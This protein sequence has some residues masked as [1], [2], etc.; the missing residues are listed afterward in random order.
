MG[1][2]P[3]RPITV[4]I[5][6]IKGAAR[7]L[8]IVTLGVNGP[9]GFIYTDSVTVNLECYAFCHSVRQKHRKCHIS[10]LDLWWKRQGVSGSWFHALLK[11]PHATHMPTKPLEILISWWNIFIRQKF[12]SYHPFW[13]TIRRQWIKKWKKR[14]NG[15]TWPNS[16]PWL[17]WWLV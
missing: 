4:S 3:I 1:V 12:L 11:L 6:K 14:R 9:L 8:D 5:N 13:F 16:V 2:Q 10:M 17:S 15:G 7:Q